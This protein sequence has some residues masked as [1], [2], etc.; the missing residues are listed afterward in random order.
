MVA[1]FGDITP[2]RLPEGPAME[3]AAEAADWSPRG[4]RTL[5]EIPIALTAMSYSFSTYGAHVSKAKSKYRRTV[6]TRPIPWASIE[7]RRND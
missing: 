6:L 2:T 1:V 7:L 3:P 5:E 4:W